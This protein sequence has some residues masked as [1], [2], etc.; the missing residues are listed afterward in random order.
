MRPRKIVHTWTIWTWAHAFFKHQMQEWALWL[1]LCKNNQ[2]EL[3]ILN[4]LLVVGSVSCWNPSATKLEHANETLKTPRSFGAWSPMPTSPSFYLPFSCDTT[5]VLNPLCP[6]HMLLRLLGYNCECDSNINSGCACAYSLYYKLCAL[7][8][9][10]LQTTRGGCC[11]L[12]AVSC[13]LADK[14]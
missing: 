8:S 3:F 11:Y 13:Q 14:E 6:L 9:L 7:R 12:L 2:I 10:D 5:R 4:W 1:F